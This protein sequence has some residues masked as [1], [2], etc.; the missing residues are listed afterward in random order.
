MEQTVANMIAVCQEVIRWA[1]RH[2]VE[3]HHPTVFRLMVICI[4]TVRV[5]SNGHMYAN[6]NVKMSLDLPHDAV[7]ADH[8]SVGLFQQQ[9]N[10]DGTSKGW[11]TVQ[12][13]MSVEGSTDS[14]LNRLDELGLATWSGPPLGERCQAVQ[15]SAFPDRYAAEHHWAH[16]FVAEHLGDIHGRAL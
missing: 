9:V 1:E 7:G 3:H 2:G 11:G 15:V 12:H 13:C 14:F 4:M 10:P 5:E 8:F 16:M 6:S